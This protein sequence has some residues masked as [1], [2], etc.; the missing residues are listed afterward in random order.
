MEGEEEIS[1]HSRYLEQ[2]MLGLRTRQGVSNSLLSVC[3]LAD[4]YMTFL[5]KHPETFRQVQR[6][7]D[8]GLMQRVEGGVVLTRQGLLIADTLSA[9]LLQ[10]VKDSIA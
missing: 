8:L 4:I 9:E 6:L 7:C 5:Q 2:V 1:S 3:I 10:D